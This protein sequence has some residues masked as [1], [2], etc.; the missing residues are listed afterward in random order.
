MCVCHLHT[1]KIQ[2]GDSLRVAGRGAPSSVWRWL[3]KARWTV[4]K[5]WQDLSSGLQTHA[6]TYASEHTYIDIYVYKNTHKHTRRLKAQCCIISLYFKTRL[7]GWRDGLAVKSTNYSYRSS[8]PSTYTLGP[9]WS[10]LILAPRAPI[11]R[12]SKGIL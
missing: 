5:E 6:Y 12:A 10:S 7:G 8:S 11:P 9:S 1:G 2:T 3:R 4:P